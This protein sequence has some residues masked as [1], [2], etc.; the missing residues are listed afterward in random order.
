LYRGLHGDGAALADEM[1]LRKENPHMFSKK[2]QIARSVAVASMALFLAGPVFANSGAPPVS[3]IKNES[4]LSAGRSPAASRPSPA[5]QTSNTSEAQRYASRE[6][7]AQSLETFRG[8]AG[9]V[10]IGSGALIAALLIVL[11]IVLI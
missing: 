10:Y 9:G 6:A 11:I 8:G 5:T 1:D 2:I 3:A 4:A 7:A